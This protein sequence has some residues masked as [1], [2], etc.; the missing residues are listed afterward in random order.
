MSS[1]SH[2]KYDHLYQS[3]LDSLELSLDASLSL[4]GAAISS[5]GECLDF[6]IREQRDGLDVNTNGFWQV[7]KEIDLKKVYI[8][9]HFYLYT[10]VRE[11][12]REMNYW[13]FVE[14]AVEADGD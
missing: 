14:D 8:K 10:E 9:H 1:P 3:S 4:Q 5:I 2:K 13:H 7:E 6:Y 11:K 12:L